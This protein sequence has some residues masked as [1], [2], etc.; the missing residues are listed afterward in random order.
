VTYADALEAV[1]GDPDWWR[2]EFH[3]RETE[4][5]ADLRDR[6]RAETIRR[7]AEPRAPRPTVADQLA[8]ARLVRACPYRSAGGGCGCSRCGL[9][10]GAR[11]TTA[12]CLDCVRR[13][14][15][16]LGAAGG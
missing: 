13:Y 14:D 11:V 10:G 6:T 7:A 12:E 2:L 9:R 3:G 15:L 4:P 1:R 16:D 8:A 5:D